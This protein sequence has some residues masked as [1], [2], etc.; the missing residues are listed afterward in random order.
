[1]K[2][3]I[4]YAILGA[5]ALFMSGCVTTTNAIRVE[6][7]SDQQYYFDSIDGFIKDDKNLGLVDISIK[8]EL[9]M[10]AQEG[11]KNGFKYFAVI[12]KNINNLQGFPIT[13]INDLH[14]YCYAYKLYKDADYFKR[15]CPNIR[16]IKIVYFKK[17][18]PGLP[19][20]NIERVLKSEDAKEI[21]K[22]VETI[23]I[24]G[25]RKTMKP[26]PKYNN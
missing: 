2:K 20:W 17:A 12:N 11:K 3:Y 5:A 8:A 24:R 15:R 7:N 16:G 26:F 18:I 14:E 9:L 1:M 4:K 19:L 21:L 6:K 25:K 23:S 13:K 22:E 10:A